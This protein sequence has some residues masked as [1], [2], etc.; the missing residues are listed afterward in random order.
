MADLKVDILTNP[1][2]NVRIK[3]KE[4]RINTSEGRKKARKYQ[5]RSVI[6]LT[7]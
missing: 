6:I 5:I 1:E 7:N 2:L 4:I 3:W